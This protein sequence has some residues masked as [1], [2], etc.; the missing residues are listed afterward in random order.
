MTGKEL[1]ELQKKIAQDVEFA[2]T[3]SD[4]NEGDIRCVYAFLEGW[5]AGAL[6]AC[7]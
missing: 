7:A 4:A 3:M 5:F 2:I 6:K 1:L